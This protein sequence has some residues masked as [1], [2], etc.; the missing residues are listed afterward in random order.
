M[1]V[2]LG[3]NLESRDGTV[4]KDA[5]VLNGLIE[6]EGD[7]TIVRKRPGTVDLGNVKTGT[8]QLLYAWNGINTIQADFLNRGTIATIVSG[9]SSQNLS[10]TN[11]GLQFS[12]QETGS[13]AATPLLMLKNRT[14]AFSV[15]KSGTIAAITLP[16]GLGTTLYS[17][18]S[19]TR[20]G[21]TATATL[22]EPT[23]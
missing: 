13:D 23:R 9:P 4:S 10:P 18:T 17:V 6:R 12:A 7:S 22:A 19:L 3:V 15:N 2:P 21:G 11:A 5:K 8:A 20:S 14:Q 1:R 16:A